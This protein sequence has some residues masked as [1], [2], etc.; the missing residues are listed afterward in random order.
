MLV[1]NAV[2]LSQFRQARAQ[3]E[4]LTGVD[5]KLLAVLEA[6]VSLMSFHERLTVLADSENAGLLTREADALRRALLEDRR[7]TTDALGRLPPAAQSDPTLLTSLA[8]IQD[9]LP[10]QLDAITALAKSGDWGAVRS[11]LAGQV[12]PLEARSSTL[13]ANIDREVDEERAR[14]V[15]TIEQAQQRILL[16]VP[17]TAVLTLLFAGVLGLVITRSITRPLRRLMDASQALGRGDFHDRVP[18][19]GQDEMAELGRVVNDTAGMLRDHIAATRRAEEALRQTQAALAHVTRVTTVG[20]I[21]ASIAHE[22]NQPLAGAITN[23]NTCLRWLQRDPPGLAEAQEAASR[24]AADATRAAEI[25]QRV[26]N[27]FRKGASQREPVAVNEVIRE[28]DGAHIL[29]TLKES[30]WILSGP[31][32]A[33]TRLGI[34]RS[35]L[36]FRMKRLG[37]ERPRLG[38]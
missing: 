5:Q 2:L 4:I 16:I 35:T 15:S 31:R 24:S 7:R 13:V 22:V 10:A 20:E 6:H 29:A 32:G 34:N 19:T 33:A 38:E 23:A 21:T 36:Q 28:M 1:G 25:I 18:I 26:R 8:V 3:T 37:I 30:R 9:A 11:R 27:L 17:I 12:R 14:A